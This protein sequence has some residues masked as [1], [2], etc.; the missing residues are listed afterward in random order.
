MRKLVLIAFVAAC[1]KSDGKATGADEPPAGAQESVTGT[2]VL[3]G[4]FTA[5]VAWKP[6]LALT[7]GCLSETDWTVDA[8]Y[9]DGNDAFV[10]LAVSSTRGMTLTSNKV[11]TPEPLKSEGSAG[12]KGSCK[13][14]RR[15]IDGVMSI[16]LDGTLTGK[17]GTE[18]VKGHL[19][20][21]CR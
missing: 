8:S 16:D 10:A 2:L 17:P 18:T 13:L 1:S 12:I 9:T 21:V 6:D 7:C 11:G 3:G 5:S 4:I 14:D 19:D 20:V 15:N